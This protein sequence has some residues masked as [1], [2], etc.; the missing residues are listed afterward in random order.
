MGLYLVDSVNRLDYPVIQC[1]NLLFA[2]LLV[3]AIVMVDV[4]YAF[5]D[6]RIRYR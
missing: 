5:L 1:L 2:A 4:C 6:P 3:T